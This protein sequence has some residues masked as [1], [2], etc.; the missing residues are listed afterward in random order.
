[1]KLKTAQAI[2][3]I[4]RTIENLTYNFKLQK[5]TDIE[6]QILEVKEF[7]FGASSQFEIKNKKVKYKNG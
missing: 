6:W 4:I 7:L 3:D 5:V 1:M 2:Y